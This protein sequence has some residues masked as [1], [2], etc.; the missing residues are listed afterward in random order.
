MDWYAYQNI[1]I[2][3]DV[4]SRMG[5]V[6]LAFERQIILFFSIP[7]YNSILLNPSLFGHDQ[8][9]LKDQ[10]PLIEHLPYEQEHLPI[11]HWSFGLWR[12]HQFEINCFILIGKDVKW[13][14]K[15]EILYSKPLF[16]SENFKLSIW[17]VCQQSHKLSSQCAWRTD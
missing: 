8:K 10:Y 15:W 3:I 1:S 2:K 14:S 17:I 5:S 13:S 6:G 7:R 12:F 11:I 4:W 16:V 9:S